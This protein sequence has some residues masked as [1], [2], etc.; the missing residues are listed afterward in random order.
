MAMKMKTI[1]YGAPAKQI[2]ATPD[3]YVSL[4]FKHAKATQA[5]PGLAVLEEGRYYVKAGTIYPANDSTAIGV[6][7]NDYDVTDGDAMLA[8]VIHGFIKTAALP[9][10]PTANALAAMKQLSFAPMISMGVVLAATPVAIAVSEA[11][12]TE[13]QIRV[14]LAGATFRD[15]AETLSNWTITG[16]AVNKVVVMS[17]E[18]S[19]DKT[20]VTVTTKN[21]AAAVAGS[22]AI[23]PKAAAISTGQVPVAA[24]TIATVA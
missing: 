7:L 24:T 9:T 5:A 13:H 18:V 2:L 12:N 23:V 15:A 3:H 20:Y 4:G 6:V 19:A 8:V 10:L 14:D 22:T 16:E 21:S 11:I 17:I 1:N